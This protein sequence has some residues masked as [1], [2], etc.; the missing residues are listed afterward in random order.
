[1]HTQIKLGWICQ[2]V[3]KGN[4]KK[5][6]YNNPM[7]AFSFSHRNVALQNALLSRVHA[8]FKIISL[9][10]IAKHVNHHTIM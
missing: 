7:L 2:V 5:D 1:M 6:P 3:E 4:P 9:A 10:I 8:Q